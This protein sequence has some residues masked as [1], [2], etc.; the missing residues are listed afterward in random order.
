MFSKLRCEDFIFFC[1]IHKDFSQPNE[2]GKTPCCDNYFNKEPIFTP[3]GVCYATNRSV[4]EEN[5]F[6]FSAMEIWVNL[7]FPNV[8]YLGQ[9]SYDVLY[10]HY[11][12]TFP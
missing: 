10:L 7:E 3:S 5:P 9:F 6:E 4:T 8:T 2:E 12:E 1:D 11:G